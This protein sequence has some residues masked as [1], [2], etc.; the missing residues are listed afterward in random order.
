MK[1][2]S[3]Q[4]LRRGYTLIEVLAAGAVISVG[5]AA[6][7]S[8]ASSLM[9]QEELAWRVS[10]T[11]NYQENMV[12]LWQ[13]GLSPAGSKD[14]TNIGAVMPSQTY[15]ALLNE[16]INSTPYLIETGSTTPEGLGRLLSAAVTA[17]VNV[18]SDP[19]KELEG[20]TFTLTAYRPSLPTSLRTGALNP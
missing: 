17:T 9:V 11:R 8:L 3:L 7:A 12:R 4:L 16:A 20:A 5:M 15:S 6:A 2:R 13:L 10:I 18:S 1:C 14:A 19:K